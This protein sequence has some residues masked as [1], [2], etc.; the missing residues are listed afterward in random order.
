MSDAEI[1]LVDGGG[2]GAGADMKFGDVAQ[3]D[4]D[5]WNTRCRKSASYERTCS[6]SERTHRIDGTERQLLGVHKGPNVL[7]RDV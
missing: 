6:I 3:V 5:L 7:H 1:A 2:V 4:A